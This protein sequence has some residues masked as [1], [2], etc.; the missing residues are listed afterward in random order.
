MPLGE[1]Q[2]NTAPL[3]YAKLHAPL[4][5]QRYHVRGVNEASLVLSLHSFF[6]QVGMKPE[7]QFCLTLQAVRVADVGLANPAPIVSWSAY[8]AATLCAAHIPTNSHTGNPHLSPGISI[9]SNATMT[10]SCTPFRTNSTGHLRCSGSDIIWLNRP[11]VVIRMSGTMS[12][13]IRLW[14]TD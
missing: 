6:R 12:I 11:G 10:S 5:W 3:C 8:T 1:L 13:F 2:P 9:W 7:Q 14:R 4:T